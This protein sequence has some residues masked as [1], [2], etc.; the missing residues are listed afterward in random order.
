M[1]SK[2]EPIVTPL[3]SD[4]NIAEPVT[5]QGVFGPNGMSRPASIENRFT[6]TLQVSL[7]ASAVPHHV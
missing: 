3:H 6:V 2:R 5:S 1:R 7:F 4:K